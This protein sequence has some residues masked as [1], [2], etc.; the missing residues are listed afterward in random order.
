MLITICVW[1]V[2]S[3]RQPSKCSLPQTERAVVNDMCMLYIRWLTYPVCLCWK[4]GTDSFV[5]ESIV[6]S[7]SVSTWSKKFKDCCGAVCA[8]YTSR[9]FLRAFGRLI[10]SWY[11]NDPDS[12]G[13]SAPLF[14]ILGGLQPPQ[15]PWFLHRWCVVTL[16]YVVHECL[17]NHARVCSWRFVLMFP[18]L[19]G[20]VSQP[21][22]GAQW[23]QHTQCWL[24]AQNGRKF[25]S[26]L[27]NNTPE[28]NIIS[29]V[30]LLMDHL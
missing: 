27:Y 6:P 11:N 3:S 21:P 12:Q 17:C 20:C 13:G 23:K 30:A 7:A 10:S 29:N 25:N 16:F 1:G 9:S 28:A 19:L 2:W 24:T 22:R 26:H 4:I 8:R 15:L 14:Q 5:A 18:V